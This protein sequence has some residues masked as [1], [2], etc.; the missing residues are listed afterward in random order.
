MGSTARSGP[1]RPGAARSGPERP[2][3][4]RSVPGRA[5]RRPGPGAGRRVRV[6]VECGYGIPTPEKLI[7][8]DWLFQVPWVD[9]LTGPVADGVNA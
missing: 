6:G 9:P 5:V 7:V 1:E 8:N 4:A 3:A 2:G